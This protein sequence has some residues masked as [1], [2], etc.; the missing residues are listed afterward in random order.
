M[1]GIAGIIEFASQGVDQKVVAR[2]AEMLAHRGPDGQGTWFGDGV[3]LA[4]RRLAIIDLSPA[5]DQPMHSADGAATI[6]FNGEIYNYR[7]LAQQLRTAGFPLRTQSDTEVILGLYQ[8]HGERCVEFLRGMFAFAI[9]DHRRHELFLARDRIGVKPLYYALTARGFAFGSEIKAVVASG[10]SERVVDRAAVA[11]FLRFMV[12]PQPQTIFEGIKKLD[13]GHT[14]RVTR[15]GRTTQRCYWTSESYATPRADLRESEYIEAL[16]QRLLESV[17]YHMVADVPVSAFLSGGLDSSAVVA[18][19]RQ[20]APSQ[21]IK[22]F[23]TVFPAQP[24]YDEFQHAHEVADAKGLEHQTH[25]FSEDFLDDY[26]RIVWHLDEPFAVPSALATYYLAKAAAASTKVVLTGD[27]GDELFAGYLG[28]QNDRYRDA[29]P[30]GL[31]A[32]SL[33]Y[34]AAVATRTVVRGQDALFARIVCG[35]GRRGGSEGLRYSEQVAQN[36][37]NAMGQV[38]NR[39]LFVSC[40]SAWRGNLLAHYYDALQ[41]SDTLQRKLYAEYRTRLVDEMLMKVDRMTMA[42]SLEARVPLLDHPLVELALSMPSD[43]KL[44]DRDGKRTGKYAL[45]KVMEKYLPHGIIYRRKQGFNIPIEQ[46]KSGRF[47]RE[48]AQRLREGHLMKAGVV[49]GP[50]VERL[51]AL[52]GDTCHNYRSMLQ[53]LF[54]LEVWTD[55]YTRRFGAIRFA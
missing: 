31:A 1:C 18:L 52:Q 50:G 13:P 32:T 43:L 22:S 49:T 55:V 27:G 30:F 17:R 51:I 14:M 15:D 39:D 35:L 53:A 3:G 2:M 20:V 34:R 26:E 28:H 11:R 21:S 41:S 42:H 29:A 44:R 46:W 23:S 7:E 54:A 25:A 10:I 37:L 48:A 8:Q 24:D 9:W 19:M 16:E 5:S 47:G 4:H 12:V 33:L 40:L 36:S 45:K 38:L 6:V